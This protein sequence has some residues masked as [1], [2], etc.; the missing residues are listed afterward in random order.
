M[1]VTQGIADVARPLSLRFRALKGWIRLPF[2]RPHRATHPGDQLWFPIAYRPR[3][4]RP[5]LLDRARVLAAAR[6]PQ[7]SEP[8]AGP[9][10]E[11]LLEVIRAAG[12]RELIRP[13][14]P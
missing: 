14:V 11:A 3:G 12:S 2:G 8:P 7:K 13:V 5:K 9:T 4:D 1:Q 6:P 10:R